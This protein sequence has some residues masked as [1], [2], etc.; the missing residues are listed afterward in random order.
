MKATLKNSEAGFTLF[1]ALIAIMLSSMI[2]LFLCTSL[3]Q[4]NQVNELL[5]SDS[6]YVESASI[7]IRGSRQMEWHLF[8][9]QLEGYLENTEFIRFD[10]RL[11]LVN[12]EDAED[13]TISRVKYGRAQTGHQSFYRSKDNG[14][15][16]M[17]MDIQSFQLRVEEEYLHLS[18]VFQ[19]GEKYTGRIWVKSWKKE[20]KGASD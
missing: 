16:A 8:L 14:H 17:L 20:D 15:N 11:L 7:K 6:Q 1:E 2:L 12:E 9:N 19:N 10:G 4:L 3:Q 5:I 18:F 13:Q